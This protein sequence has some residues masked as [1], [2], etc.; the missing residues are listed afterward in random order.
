MAQQTVTVQ[1]TIAADGTLRLALPRQDRRLIY[2]VQQVS[3]R[4]PSV[5]SAAESGLVLDGDQITPM[6]PQAGA[7]SGDPYIQ[8]RPGSSMYVEWTGATV[9][10]LCIATFIYD[11][12]VK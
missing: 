5:G 7:A 8:V 4:A 12:G 9:G 11:D 6:T 10:A 2:T 3:T 1:G